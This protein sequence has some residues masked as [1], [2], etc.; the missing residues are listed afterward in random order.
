MLCVYIH[1]CIYVL[2]KYSSVVMYSIVYYIM[3]YYS[4][5]DPS[6]RAED[7]PPS[8]GKATCEVSLV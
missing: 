3:I 4:V 1:I 5:A 8:G 7:R 2:L 6:G